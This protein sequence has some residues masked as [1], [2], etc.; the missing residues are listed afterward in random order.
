MTRPSLTLIIA[1]DHSLFREGLALQLAKLAPGITIIQA[2][3]ADSLH[4]ALKAHNPDL[5]LLDWFIPELSPTTTIHQLS[6]HEPPVP[7]VV[8]SAT[9]SL[10]D[11]ASALDAGALGFVPKTLEPEQLLKA[12][13]LILGGH[14]YLP[15]GLA[16][17][18]AAWRR[19]RHAPTLTRRQKEVLAMLATGS[20]NHHIA[21]SLGISHA[22]VKSHINT[23]FNILGA[24]NRTACVHSARESG[25]LD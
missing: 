4:S 25:L 22:T 13:E 18:L 21:K 6:Q 11:I 9:E 1:D 20:S 14:L 24:E 16:R 12:I 2:G 17:Q 7:V 19:S 3:T 5:V 23:L 15:A 8:V 10:S